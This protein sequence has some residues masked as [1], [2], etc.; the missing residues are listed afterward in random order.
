M[1][2][3]LAARNGQREMESLSEN[4][5]NSFALQL[6][7]PS[8]DDPHSRHNRKQTTQRQTGRAAEQIFGSV[9][10]AFST[11][12]L[13]RCGLSLATLPLHRR[14]AGFAPANISALFLHARCL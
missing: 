5:A 7:L 4:S 9:S 12:A 10:L 1:T 6:H 14:A 11:A 2:K 13:C 3:S 8:P